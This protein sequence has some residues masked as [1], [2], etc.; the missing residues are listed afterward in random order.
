MGRVIGGRIGGLAGAGVMSAVHMVVMAPD[1]QPP[2]ASDER[3]A[4]DA[5]VK[6]AEAVS[7]LAGRRLTAEQKPAAGSIVHYA[8]GAVMGAS[9]GAAVVAM[10]AVSVGHGVAMGA[11]LWVG[12]HAVVVPALGLAPSPLRQPAAP[13]ALE[14]VL[15]LLYGVTTAGT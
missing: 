10:P 14:F 12:C 3:A 4:D 8:F 13:E 7:H 15:H 11:A 5:T 6:V 9:Y 2:P 1:Q